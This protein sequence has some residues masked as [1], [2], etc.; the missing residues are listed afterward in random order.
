[1]MEYLILALLVMLLAACVEQR[2]RVAG[3]T[4]EIRSEARAAREQ[5]EATLQRIT[6]MDTAVVQGLEDFVNGRL[7]E[8]KETLRVAAETP[9]PHRHQWRPNSHEETNKQQ[10]VIHV[11]CVEGCR[12]TYREVLNLDGTPVEEGT[13]VGDY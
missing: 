5:Q 12:D 4:R 9:K 2:F 11:C 3:I 10:R 13:T 1:M 7:A 6:M 8:A